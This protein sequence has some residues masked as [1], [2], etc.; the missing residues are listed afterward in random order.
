MFE[1][2]IGAKRKEGIDTGMRENMAKL[3][4]KKT[5]AGIDRVKDAGIETEMDER[6]RRDEWK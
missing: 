6:G 1:G 2:C 3:P 5:D 4:Q